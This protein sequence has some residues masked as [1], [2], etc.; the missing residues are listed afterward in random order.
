MALEVRRLVRASPSRVFAA[1]TEPAQ[2]R[3]WWGP[4]GVT[5]PE[6]H[7]DLCVGG[8]FRI[9]NQLPDGTL[10]WATGHFER[11][12]PPHELVYTWRFDPG[13]D[14]ESR[15]V[16]RFEAREGATEVVVRHE[17][18]PNESMRAEHE[19]G[20]H[21]CLDGLVTHLAG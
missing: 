18:I 5:C 4:T 1:W 19:A 7:V 10:V 13:P 20:W 2:I 3:E 9:A 8:T 15:V 12:D 21:G 6:A 14:A 17:G 16:V 11:I